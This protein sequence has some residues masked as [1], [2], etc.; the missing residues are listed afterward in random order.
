[1]TI[2]RTWRR[3]WAMGPLRARWSALIVAL[4]LA[5]PSSAADAAQ[6]SE[7]IVRSASGPHAPLWRMRQDHVDVADDGRPL[8]FDIRIHVAHR[9]D[10]IAPQVMACDLQAAIDTSAEDGKLRPFREINAGHSSFRG[11]TYG[12]AGVN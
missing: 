8:R 5:P 3:R 9:S 4:L 12:S 7:Q 1:M 11:S 6:P 10:G 2:H